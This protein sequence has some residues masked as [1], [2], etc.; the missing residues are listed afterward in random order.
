LDHYAASAARKGS[1]LCGTKLSSLLDVHESSPQLQV[2]HS[3]KKL[4]WPP[5]RFRKDKTINK[6]C[7]RRR[8]RSARY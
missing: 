2:T 6:T 1:L 3:L 4:K 5:F 7:R 8:S